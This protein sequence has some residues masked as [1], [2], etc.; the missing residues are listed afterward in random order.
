VKR[1][2]LE[3]D[4]E[5]SIEKALKHEEHLQHDDNEEPVTFAE[6]S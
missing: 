3:K 1:K 6:E 2:Q 5:D 4:L